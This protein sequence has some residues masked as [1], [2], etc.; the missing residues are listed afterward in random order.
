M[1]QKPNRFRQLQGGVRLVKT[2]IVGVVDLV[3][4]MHNRI[5][6]APYLPSGPVQHIITAIAAITYQN[7]R[8]STR[9]IGGGADLA[10]ERLS[11]DAG[12]VQKG[13]KADALQAVLNG[14]IGD[15]LHETG[16]SLEIQMGFRFNNESLKLNRDELMARIPNCTGKILLMVHG[17][18]MNDRQWTRKGR[19]HGEALARQSGSTEVYLRY[20]SGLHISQNGRKLSELL[21]ELVQHWPVEVRELTILTHS[22]GGLITRSAYHYGS[23]LGESWTSR[24]QKIF[25]LGSPHHGAPLERL[26]NQADVLLASFALSRP[27]A[28]LGK[29]R[30]AGITDLRYGNLT[31]EDWQEKDRFA[32]AAD[33]RQ[34]IPLPANVRCFT[35]AAMIGKAVRGPA[36]KLSKLTGDGLVG[37]DSALGVHK[38]PERSLHFAPQHTRMVYQCGHLD[39]LS[40]ERVGRI[41]E[42]WMAS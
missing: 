22:M 9:L 3:E 41:L 14:V 42:E 19:N 10:L 23:E 32:R 17:S 34:H 27:L 26:G 28:R 40:D 24:V 12:P 21:E 30:S 16:N 8:W 33:Q 4:A 31:D 15:Y 7:I 1:T 11:R 35:V 5:V 29:I 39:L 37:L 36:L 38:D 2:G 6:H 20:N 18:C 25:F 13:T